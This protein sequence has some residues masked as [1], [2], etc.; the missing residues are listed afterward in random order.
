[1]WPRNSDVLSPPPSS[2][3]SSNASPSEGA[4]LTGSYGCTPQSLPKFWHPSHELLRDNGFTQQGYHKYRRRC[5]NGKVHHTKKRWWCLKTW[6]CF[7]LLTVSTAFQRGNGWGS[8]SLRRWTLCSGSGPSSWETT[9]T[10][11]C[12]RSSNS[13]RWRTPKKT[14]G[15]SCC[16]GDVSPPAVD[17]A[18]KRVNAHS[19]LMWRSY[20]V[21]ERLDS[22][23]QFL[24]W[25]YLLDINVKAS[26]KRGMKTI[27][28]GVVF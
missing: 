1:M 25:N 8:A 20:D 19:E 2:Y 11:R 12:T 9:S 3:S 28:K 13:T 24:K 6:S 15:E 5:L 27:L 17:G 10:G 4:P 14:T 16:Y 18:V 7:L 26:K 22:Q 23:I 21:S